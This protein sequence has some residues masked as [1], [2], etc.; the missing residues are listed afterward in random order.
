MNHPELPIQ[1][2]DP[3][4]NQEVLRQRL[5]EGIAARRK[6]A[7]ERGLDFAVLAHGRAYVDTSGRSPWQD[8]QIL[9][10][11][12]AV[13][14]TI[15]SRTGGRCWF[16]EPLVIRLRR[17][18]HGLVA[19]YCNLLGERQ[20]LF[21]EV[22]LR[23][24]AEHPADPSSDRTPADRIAALEQRVERLERRLNDSR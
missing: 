2:D 18:M 4:I 14:P 1:V 3:E 10:N 21:N 16:L 5:A 24:L 13:H 12:I 22:L 8:L 7:D 6:M 17:E 20:I 9:K 19:F 11:K 15:V 23:F